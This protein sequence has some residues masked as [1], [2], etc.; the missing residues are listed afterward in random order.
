MPYTALEARTTQ[1]GWPMQ[2][3]ATKL[4]AGAA[5]EARQTERDSQRVCKLQ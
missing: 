3:A 4:R 1:A 2:A 5:G